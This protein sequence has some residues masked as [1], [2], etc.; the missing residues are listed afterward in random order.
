MRIPQG[1]RTVVSC[2][3]AHRM[4]TSRMFRLAL[5]IALPA[6]LTMLISSC[7][8]E[9]RLDIQV[10]TLLDPPTQDAPAVTMDQSYAM[11]GAF[12]EEFGYALGR[13]MQGMMAPASD[14]E[15]FVTRQIL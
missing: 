3:Y 13:R 14:A 5:A 7:V 9:N 6:A 10:T 8:K 11:Y 15:I 12:D 1:F 2:K 4:K